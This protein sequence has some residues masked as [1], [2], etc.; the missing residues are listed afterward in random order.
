MVG[1]PVTTLPVRLTLLGTLLFAGACGYVKR[2]DFE[3]EVARLRQEMSDGDARVS[4]EV[5]EVEA[6][7]AARM[8]A[9][10]N[11]LQDLE[12]EF[13]V[14]FER[15]ETSLRVHAPVHFGFDESR[16]AGDEV[17]VLERIASVLNEYYPEALLTVEGFTDPSGSAEYNLRLGKARA[18]AVRSVLIE[19][20]GLAPDRNRQLRRVRGPAGDSG[21]G[22]TGRRGR[23]E[24]ARGHRDRPSR[25]GRPGGSGDRL[26]SPHREGRRGPDGDA[27]RPSRV[28]GAD[29]RPRRV[30]RNTAER[31]IAA[32]P[33]VRPVRGS[34]AKPQPSSSATTGLTYA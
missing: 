19:R 8:E 13:G 14:R 17:V 4:S 12:D 34:P 1:T 6:R 3:T 18:D 31:M 10:E 27:V 11:G 22:R 28:P 5:R 33:S 30:I 21:G 32:A 15:L 9:V 23:G 16:L 7:M 24:P 26:S 20:G 29:Q 25:R 2:D